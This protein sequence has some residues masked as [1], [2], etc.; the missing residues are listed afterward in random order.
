MTPRLMA[1]L[2]AADLAESVAAEF[3]GMASYGACVVACRL[4]ALVAQE[5]A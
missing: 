5:R 1:L 2:A 3:G 4:R